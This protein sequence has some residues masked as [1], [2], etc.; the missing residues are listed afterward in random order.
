VEPPGLA[1]GRGPDAQDLN[2]EAITRN[3]YGPLATR[4]E[5]IVIASA[6]ALVSGQGGSM[7]ESCPQCQQPVG[8]DHKFCS[9]C[10]APLS[11]G[12]RPS[13]FNTSA[14]TGERNLSVTGTGNIFQN[15]PTHFGDNI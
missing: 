5:I 1:G 13:T 4:V 10:A 15:S 12:A 6:F 14:V 2:P 11:I 3:L 9:N 8:I 7:K